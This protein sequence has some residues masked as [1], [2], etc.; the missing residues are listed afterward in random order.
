MKNRR[1]EI[2]DTWRAEK[3]YRSRDRIRIE[4]DERSSTQTEKK[5][6]CNPSFPYKHKYNPTH[7]QTNKQTEK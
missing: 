2:R 5:H 4:M 6:H 1:H 7:E 3:E